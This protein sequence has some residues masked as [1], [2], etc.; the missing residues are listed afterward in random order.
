MKFQLKNGILNQVVESNLDFISEKE[1]TKNSRQSNIII[2]AALFVGI[3][4]GIDW[5]VHLF[6]WLVPILSGPIGGFQ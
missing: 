2:E 5:F 6:H 4:F 3:I 1:K